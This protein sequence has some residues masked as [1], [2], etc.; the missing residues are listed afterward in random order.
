ME[1]DLLKEPI[2]V[3]HSE[4]TGQGL[5]VFLK[6]IVLYDLKYHKKCIIV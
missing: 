4:V 3:A 2:Y 1:L 6:K 5:I